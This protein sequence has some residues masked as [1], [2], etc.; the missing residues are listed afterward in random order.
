M[1]QGQIVESGTGPDLLKKSGVYARLWNA[2]KDFA[3]R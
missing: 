3:A 1:E 2:T